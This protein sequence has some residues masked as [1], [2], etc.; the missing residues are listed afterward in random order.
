MPGRVSMTRDL[1]AIFDGRTTQGET[2]AIIVRFV[3]NNWDIIQGLVRIDV[4]SKSVNANELAEVLKGAASQ[5]FCS[6][7]TPLKSQ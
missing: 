6:C 4:C 1:S 5:G 2:I 7:L 3:D